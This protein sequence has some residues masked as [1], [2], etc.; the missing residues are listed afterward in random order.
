MVR[1]KLTISVKAA[2]IQRTTLKYLQKAQTIVQG[3]FFKI[4][5]L[6]P[7]KREVAHDFCT[8]L[9]TEMRLTWASLRH[10]FQAVDH[11]SMKQDQKRD[12]SFHFFFYQSYKERKACVITPYWGK[13]W[14][15]WNHPRKIKDNDFGRRCFLKKKRKKKRSWANNYRVSISLKVSWKKISISM[16]KFC[17]SASALFILA[18]LQGLIV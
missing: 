6:G 17:L 11:N 18:P 16:C 12:G 13:L 15:C 2:N 14:M 1:T 3:H 8:I 7:W 10:N 4:M 5:S 9:R